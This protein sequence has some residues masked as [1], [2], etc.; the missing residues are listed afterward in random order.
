MDGALRAAQPVAL[1]NSSPLIIQGTPN[2]S[3]TMPETTAQKVCCRGMVT[4]PPSAR[5]LNASAACTADSKFSV[6]RTP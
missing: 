4:S 2:R 3:V 5:P 1:G 6:I